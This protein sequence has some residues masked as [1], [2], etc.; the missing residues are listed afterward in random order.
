MLAR[1]LACCAP[2]AGLLLASLPR[3]KHSQDKSGGGGLE[4]SSGLPG[5]CALCSDRVDAAQRWRP[6]AIHPRGAPWN[7]SPARARA[8]RKCG[9]PGRQA[10]IEQCG[11][12]VLTCPVLEDSQG[13]ALAQ[14]GT[15]L[16]GQAGLKGWPSYYLPPV[17]VTPEAI[18]AWALQLLQVGPGP[19]RYL[20]AS[21][22][23]LTVGRG[24]H[25]T[26]MSQGQACM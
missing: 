25:R 17:L 26:D 12:S 4:P 22:C 14:H 7:S 23:V 6:F 3:V 9:G 8:R 1:A 15:R 20:P 5:W 21:V 24:D 18:V 13:R 11:T 19:P 16:C 2:T 10:V